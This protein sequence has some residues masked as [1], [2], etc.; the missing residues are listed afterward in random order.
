MQNLEHK[1]QPKRDK[2]QRNPKKLRKKLDERTR[3]SKDPNATRRKLRT[4]LFTRNE[5]LTDDFLLYFFSYFFT[6]RNALQLFDEF[7]ELRGIRV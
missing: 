4:I 3:T 1:Q 6:L 7:F 5:A 2:L